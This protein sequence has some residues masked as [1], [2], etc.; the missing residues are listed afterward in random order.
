VHVEHLPVARRT[1]GVEKGLGQSAWN[2]YGTITTMRGL[3]NGLLDSG[4]RAL[5]VRAMSAVPRLKYI[6][7]MQSGISPAT[8][9]SYGYSSQLSIYDRHTSSLY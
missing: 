7:K 5:V 6:F 1:A 4:V 3:N 9:V 2:W 8:A